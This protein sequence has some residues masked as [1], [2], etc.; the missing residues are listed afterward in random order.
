MKLTFRIPFV[1]VSKKNNTRRITVRGRPMIAP[2]RQVVNQQR[3]IKALAFQ[4]I[5]ADAVQAAQTLF[6]GALRSDAPTCFGRNEVAVTITRHVADE[7]VT[8]EIEDLGPPPKG[9]TG[10]DRDTQNLA[11]TICDALNGIAW[12]DDRQVQTITI[13]RT[14]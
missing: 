12:D 1:P 2:S 5:G 10:R 7:C 14:P 8:V 13:R 6:L 4:A 3:T 9:R 11:D